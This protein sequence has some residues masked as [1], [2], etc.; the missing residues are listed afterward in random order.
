M[1]LQVS[2]SVGGNQ[3]RLGSADPDD[4]GIVFIYIYFLS[5]ILKQLT[6]LKVNE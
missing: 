1:S 6:N 2:D 3:V 4:T 5:I